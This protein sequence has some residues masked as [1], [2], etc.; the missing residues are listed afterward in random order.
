MYHDLCF[1]VSGTSALLFPSTES[2]HHV[3]IM[4]CSVHDGSVCIARYF[5]TFD[6]ISDV[7][8]EK[9]MKVAVKFQNSKTQDEIGSEFY[10]NFSI[11]N[12]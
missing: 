7:D 11:F 9:R 8:M 4:M 6:L 3:L 2:S 10:G 5:E 1:E 12:S